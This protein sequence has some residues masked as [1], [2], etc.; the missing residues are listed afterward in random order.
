MGTVDARLVETLLQEFVTK[1]GGTTVTGDFDRTERLLAR[2]LP[3]DR[4]E[5]IMEEIR[6]P[7]GRNIWQKIS[8]VPDQVLS[9]YLKQEHPQTAAVVLSKIQ[10]GQAARVIESLPHEL[11]IDIVNRVLIM[12]NVPKDALNRIEH[13]LRTEFISNLSAST[14]RDL[15][16]RMA[17]VFNAFDRETEARIMTALEAVNGNSAERIRSLMFVFDDLVVLQAAH[18][19]V[20]ISKCPGGL[21]AK[22]LK[23][24]SENV[25]SAFFDNMSTRAAKMVRD[26]IELMGPQRLRDVDEAQQ[27]LLKIA[28]NLATEG[29]III[30]KGGAEDEMLI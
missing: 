4:A 25:R 15:H 28:Q 11:A 12:E 27:S 8:N 26:E 1:F 18:M 20:L 7:A 16:E 2:L 6:G 30:T 21:V 14:R 3:K 10:S 5:L 19:R 9:S 22:A 13:T 17:E 29:A 23:G 24:A